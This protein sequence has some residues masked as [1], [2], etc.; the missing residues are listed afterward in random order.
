MKLKGYNRTK[1][2]RNTEPKKGTAYKWKPRRRSNKTN[3][4]SI[5]NTEIEKRRT[6]DWIV[7]IKDSS[8]SIKKEKRFPTE[9]KAKRYVVKK[10]QRGDL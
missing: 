2:P 3:K 9:E 10:A 5:E 6:G 4:I 1:S 8:G 7:K